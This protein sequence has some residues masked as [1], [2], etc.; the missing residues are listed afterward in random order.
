MESTADNSIVS[1]D[2]LDVRSGLRKKLGKPGG[3]IVMAA[4]IVV[5]AV[6]ALVAVNVASVKPAMQVKQEAAATQIEDKALE[7]ASLSAQSING[8]ASDA[9]M[10]A[11]PA[12]TTGMPPV[13]S[14]TM[15]QA[16]AQTLPNANTGD[17]P[18]L[19]GNDASA[20]AQAQR[21]AIKATADLAET[22]RSAPTAVKNW[23]ADNAPPVEAPAAGLGQLPARF[24]PAAALAA[25]QQ[26][27][28]RLGGGQ[29]GPAGQAADPNMQ[30]EKAAFLKAAAE[31]PAPD[32]GA[33]VHPARSQF[34]LKTGAVIPAITISGVNSDLPGC[35][36]AQVSQTV[37]DSATGAYPLIP[38]GTRLYGC[39][40][41]KVA[42]G[43][44]R[45]LVVWKRLVFPDSSTLELGGMEGDDSAGYAGFKDKV[46]NH[47]ARLAAFG[48]MTSL[49]SAAFQL[50][51]PKQ[52]TNTQSLTN[53]QVAAGAV[54]QEL[55]QLG[56]Q[57]TEKNLNI[58]PTIEIRPGYRFVVMVNKDM[59]FP[60]VYR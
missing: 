37:Y 59:V 24:D 12:P 4:A 30:D 27:A 32:L 19:D 36:I 51:Q 49:F 15:P 6:A 14:P 53:Q 56:A 5:G 29:G 21:A 11:A 22:A 16:Q 45:A 13:D 18:P 1:P 41:S 52:N 44:N 58:Q 33:S 17:V 7:P 28:A 40:D 47:Y 43:Q 23:N 25:A 54:G 10:T 48:A 42:F 3:R 50:S 2:S 46:N 60:G 31:I 8:K 38:Q 35:M 57:V 39:Y 55:S 26:A 34:E 20:D 9:V